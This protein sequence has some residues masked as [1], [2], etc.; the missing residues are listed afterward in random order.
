MK[1]DK[2]KTD[3]PVRAV[4]KPESDKF[5]YS[6]GHEGKETVKVNGQS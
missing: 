2:A 4:N 1:T 5:V 6:I 3:K